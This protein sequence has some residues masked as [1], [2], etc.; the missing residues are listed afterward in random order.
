MKKNIIF[1]VVSAI[2][3][4]SAAILFYSKSESDVLFTNNIEA[5]ANDEGGG[6]GS[7]GHHAEICNHAQVEWNGTVTNCTN[8]VIACDFVNHNTCER[9]GC[10]I[11]G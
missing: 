3:I 7:L 10:P 4:S 2:A 9:K 11:H 8:L 5:L 6:Q 1:I